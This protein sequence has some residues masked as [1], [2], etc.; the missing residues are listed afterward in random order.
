M[1]MWTELACYKATCYES[2]AITNLGVH[3]NHEL[4]PRL[5]VNMY[6]SKFGLFYF[7]QGIFEFFNSMGIYVDTFMIHLSFLGDM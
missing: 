3:V 5:G 1:C 6:M 2:P 4:S 7:K